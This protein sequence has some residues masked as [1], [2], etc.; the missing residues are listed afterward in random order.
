MTL[1]TAAG[2]N[3]LPEVV[4]GDEREELETESGFESVS[5]NP[6][7][8]CFFFVRRFFKYPGL[9]SWPDFV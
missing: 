6:S 2:R 1:D 5:K 4:L 8:P 7:R 3:N 9:F